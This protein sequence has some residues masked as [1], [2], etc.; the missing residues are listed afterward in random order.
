M[1]LLVAAVAGMSAAAG[2]A[3][4]AGEFRERTQSATWDG[5]T[6]AAVTWLLALA[7]LAL[8]YWRGP[9]VA[10]IL[11][12]IGIVISLLV[13]V[14]VKS[15]FADYDSGFALVSVGIS[16]LFVLAVL[17]GILV[18]V[19]T[20]TFGLLIVVAL[21]LVVGVTSNTWHGG[22]SALL[23]GAFM[24]VVARRAA[25]RNE[26]DRPI[27]IVAHR[28]ITLRGTRFTGADLTGANFTGTEIVHTDM[29]DA[30]IEGVV[31]ENGKGPSPLVF[32]TRRPQTP[33]PSS[34]EAATSSTDVTLPSGD[35]PAES[36]QASDRETDAK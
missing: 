10:L 1:I 4:V 14:I 31:W 27:E 34:D 16:L 19:L 7:F 32:P 21:T 18:R 35:R 30:L 22:I 11:F 5:L 6:T 13:G 33:P 2:S 9:R 15:A 24:A 29:S 23:L 17:V 28:I 36:G 20:S 3:I 25:G 12:P 26:R 8:L